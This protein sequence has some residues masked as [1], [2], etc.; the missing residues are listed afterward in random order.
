[1]AVDP[2]SNLLLSATSVDCYLNADFRT[3]ISAVVQNEAFCS[4]FRGH[5]ASIA[6]DLGL[7]YAEENGMKLLGIF[8]KCNISQD[9][10]SQVP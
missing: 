3:T 5:Q 6:G 8:C 7:A 2:A 10:C 9:A 1:M 4:I